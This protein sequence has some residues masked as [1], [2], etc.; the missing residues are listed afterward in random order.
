MIAALSVIGALIAGILWLFLYVRRS[1]AP[2]NVPSESHEAMAWNA[3]T[4][5]Q[6]LRPRLERPS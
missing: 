1:Y 6:C 5:P 3:D 4:N 2:E